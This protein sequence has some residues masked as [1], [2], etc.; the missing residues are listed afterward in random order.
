MPV[1][2]EFLRGVAGIIG[3]GC[4]YMTGRAFVLYRKG[5]QTQFRFFGWAFRTTLC[6]VAVG[7]RHRIDA[8]AI[9]IW[10]FSAIAIAVAIWRY[11]REKPPEEDLT[12]TMFPGDD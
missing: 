7:I 6:M 1:S 8:A 10:T 3:I 2:L 4:A 5:Q 9:V 12:R 11:S